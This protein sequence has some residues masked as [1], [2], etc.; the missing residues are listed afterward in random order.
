M[1]AGWEKLLCMKQD[2]DNDSKRKKAR[3]LYFT[4]MEVAEIAV[5][6]GV[7]EFTVYSWRRRDGWDGEN[8]ASGLPE[9]LTA[10]MNMLIEKPDKSGKDFKEIDLLGRQ[11]AR[12]ER[13]SAGNKKAKNGKARPGKNAFTEEQHSA[14]REAI[15][16]SL[17]P[18]QRQWWEVRHQRNRAI[19]K[20]RQIGASWYFAREA[21]LD[22]LDT[23]VDKIFLSASRMQAH[24]FKRFMQDAA[25]EVDVEL[26]GG[27]IITF[28]N[29]G[30]AV[31][32]GTAVATA[33]SYTGDL[34]FDEF[35]HVK[36][37]TE[38][39]KVAS[40]N[41][42]QAGLRRTYF[43]TPTGEDHEAYAFWS[44]DL[45]NVGRNSGSAVNI[46]VSHSALKTGR[47]CED[48]V[49]RQIVTI[50]DAIEQGFDRICM[51]DLQ[52]EY[53]PD[54]I[55]NLFMCQFVRRGEVAFPFDALARCA[56]D[57]YQ[58]DVWPDW[59][60]FADR[61]LGERP[62][63]V[64]YD[65]CGGG[66]NGD[67][68]SLVVVAA[69][70]VEGGKFRVVERQQYRG[71]EFEEQ[72]ERI[73]LVTLRYNVQFI[74]IDGTGIGESVWQLT[75]KFFPSALLLNYSPALK[76][77]LVMKAQ[78]LI[79]AGRL[80]WDASFTDIRDAFLA[81]RKKVTPAGFI[82]YETARKR[83]VSHGDGAWAVMNAVYHEPMGSESGTATGDWWEF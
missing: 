33:Q 45:F 68:A 80:E 9:R 62:V 15:L 50:E 59:R 5:T 42:V 67:S 11:I 26:K 83:G 6:L 54:E 41:A 64:G 76:R 23:G 56:V 14:L 21:L 61:P 2:N 57:G 46:D 34:F 73:R 53:N 81:V 58:P 37:F 13:G 7:S 27:D 65:P 16:S 43:S 25:R 55:A 8:R 60:P 38:L 74:G 69:P 10:R 1:R 71:L 77:T 63:W 49:W 29:G 24:Q 22:L 4:G 12:L 39:R 40:G 18:H 35:F 28:A 82:T 48:Y 19:L 51:E 20:S 31:F 70:L 30:R 75:R 52:R 79:R 66:G 3:R 32:L 47:L 17:Y 36:N 44:G 72:A 78:M